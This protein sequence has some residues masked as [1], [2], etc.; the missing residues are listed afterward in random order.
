MLSLHANMCVLPATIH[1]FIV[2]DENVRDQ[3][4]NQCIVCL[5]ACSFQISF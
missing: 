1:N 3:E 2:T 4:V 5:H